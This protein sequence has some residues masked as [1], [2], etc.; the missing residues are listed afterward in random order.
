VKKSKRD[1][2][3]NLEDVILRSATASAYGLSVLTRGGLLYFAGV[4]PEQ[5]FRAYELV[6][7]KMLDS[8]RFSAPDSL[9]QHLECDDCDQIAPKRASGVPPVDSGTAGLAA[10]AAG[11]TR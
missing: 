5:V 10:K 2:L 6:F 1:Q 11:T 3:G 4:A 7:A 9:S 8:V